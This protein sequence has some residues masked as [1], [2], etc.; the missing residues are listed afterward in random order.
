[1]AVQLHVGKRGHPGEG[2][3]RT[4]GEVVQDEKVVAGFEQHQ[5]GVASDEAGS[6]GN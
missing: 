2:L 6:A 1:M 4:V 3:W 5:A